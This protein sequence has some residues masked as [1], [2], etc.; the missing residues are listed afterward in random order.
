LQIREADS[1]GGM[2]ALSTSG[3]P[4]HS[5]KQVLRCAQDDNQEIRM[6]TRNEVWRLDELVG[7]LEYK[8]G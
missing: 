2:P 4:L 6:I 3:C 7:L 8:C 5:L 1:A